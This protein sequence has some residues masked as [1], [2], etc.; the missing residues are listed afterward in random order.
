MKKFEDI[1]VIVWDIDGTLYQDLGELK[2]MMRDYLVEIMII[3]LKIDAEEAERLIAEHYQKLASTTRMLLKL[4]FNWEEIE[5]RGQKHLEIRKQFLK[6]DCQLVKMFR[7]LKHYRHLIATN[8]LELHARE[9]VA[10]L[11]LKP[12]IFEEF[13]GITPEAIKPE[14]AFFQQILDYT[15]LPAK[16]HLFVGDREETEIMPAKKIGM[17]TAKAWAEESMVAD[18]CLPEVY[19]IVRLLL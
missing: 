16:E 6:K 4:G 3:K 17:R 1:Q 8:N 7:Q 10:H 11:G 2:I 14:P 19:A 12:E 9:L 13:F 15:R 5:E 18:V